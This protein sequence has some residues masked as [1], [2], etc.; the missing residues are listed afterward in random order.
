MNGICVSGI[1]ETIL[2]RKNQMLG[3]SCPSATSSQIPHGLACGETR[4]DGIV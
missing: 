4:T 1:N 3:K 2:T